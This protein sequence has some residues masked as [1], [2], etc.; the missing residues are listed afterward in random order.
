MTAP[1][2]ALLLIGSAK[3]AGTSSSE[4]LGG[5]LMQRLNELGIDTTTMHVARALRTE[6]HTHQLLEAIDGSEL[7]IL[8]FPLYVDSLPFLLIQALERIAAH[9]SAQ[10]DVR[11]VSLA[12]I[13]NCGF[14]EAHHNHTALAICREFAT[15]AGFTWSGGLAMGSGTPL[16]GRPLAE[17]GGMARYAI[18]ALDL[19]AE[20]LA[21][22][23][24][25]PD[26]SMALMA[27]PMMS[28]RLYTF[29][30]DVGWRIEALRNGVYRQLGERPL[31]S[32]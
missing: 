3:P 19:A 16:G 14:P 28:P 32:P 29:M 5:Y 13:A 4:A 8:A 1:K 9:R 18:A 23:E 15:Q 17:A 20:A 27:Q 6:K 12:A 2:N 24:P 7:L 10:P 30:G 21:A 11:T 31:R 25:V 22:G 26:E